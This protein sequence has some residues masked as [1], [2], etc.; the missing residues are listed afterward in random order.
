MST[1]SACGALPASPAWCA[2]W[3]LSAQWRDPQP[4]PPAATRS[5]HAETPAASSNLRYRDAEWWTHALW[6]AVAPLLPAGP[7]QTTD[8]VH[9]QRQPN[10]SRQR[11]NDQS[12]RDV[13]MTQSLTHRALKTS[14]DLT[15]KSRFPSPARGC[16][17][18]SLLQRPPPLHLLPV[19]LSLFTESAFYR[20][21]RWRTAPALHFIKDFVR[22]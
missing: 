4:P 12:L 7:G 15:R 8:L 2:V 13:S 11:G 16:L 5:R 19:N 3:R 1:R 20:E 18:Q 6:K 22:S 21:V 9:P 10:P 17:T 14:C